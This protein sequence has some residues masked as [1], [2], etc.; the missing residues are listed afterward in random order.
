MP[1]T[2]REMTRLI[3][4]TLDELRDVGPEGLTVERVARRA[5]L[6]ADLVARLYPEMSN[7]LHD[8]VEQAVE[9]TIVRAI[10][11]LPDDLPASARLGLFCHRLWASLRL[12][13]MASLYR[14]AHVEHD[15]VG[16]FERLLGDV[17]LLRARTMVREL[18]AEAVASG[19]I[20]LRGRRP[21]SR[22]DRHAALRARLLASLP[23]A[24]P[25]LRRGAAGQ[26]R[27]ADPAGDAGQRCPDPDHGGGAGDR[28]PGKAEITVPDPFVRRGVLD[29]VA[30]PAL[31]CSVDLRV[32]AIN[33][34]AS[35]A[36]GLPADD[37]Q[38]RTLLDFVSEEDAGRLGNALTQATGTSEGHVALQIRL[39]APGREPWLT[40]VRIAALGHRRT[41]G[42]LIT[43]AASAGGPRG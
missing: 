6:P 24:V 40:E 42:Y 12:P 28:A 32:T 38:G 31:I 36:L 34:P 9:D 8:A 25:S 27:A 10:D 21:E 17:V 13:V 11:D 7:L 22:P 5:G 18:V 3:A 2:T 37:V 15:R 33:A 26:C 29:A 16:T 39:L 23:R 43:A 20:R 19:E 30:D 14:L 1:S 41:D 35:A 4:A